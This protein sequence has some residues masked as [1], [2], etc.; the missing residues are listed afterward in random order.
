MTVCLL[1]VNMEHAK[2]LP[3]GI[4]VHVIMDTLGQTV[5]Q[6]CIAQ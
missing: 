2:I 5:K 4:L 3:M 1:L 6:V